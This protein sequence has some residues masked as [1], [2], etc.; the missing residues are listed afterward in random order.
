MVDPFDEYGPVMPSA[1]KVFPK[2]VKNETPTKA[3]EPPKEEKQHNISKIKKTAEKPSKPSSVH[4]PKKA[5]FSSSFQRWLEDCQKI[6]LE[7]WHL[8]VKPSKNFHFVTMKNGSEERPFAYIDKRTGNIHNC[9]IG[10][11]FAY[12]RGN[13]NEEETRLKDITP[14]GVK[15]YY[16][17]HPTHPN[18]RTGN[19]VV[20]EIEEENAEAN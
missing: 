19:L 4:L 11:P 9:S 1:K 5:S 16:S 17:F 13:I 7:G 18:Y 10:E 2:I 15:S 20:E 14:Y 8:S 12:V 3:Q 6:V